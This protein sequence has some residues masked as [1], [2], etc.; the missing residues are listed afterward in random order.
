MISVCRCDDSEN[1]C[2]SFILVILDP[3]NK[4]SFIL[5]LKEFLGYSFK[6]LE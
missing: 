1:V 3:E 6:A 5:Q 2:V 4:S